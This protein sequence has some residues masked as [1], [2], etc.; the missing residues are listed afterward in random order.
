M[1]VVIKCRGQLGLPMC[2]SVKDQ[3]QRNSA[4]NYTSFLDIWN[5]LSLADTF[6]AY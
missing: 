4:I 2:L 1:T 5:P 6:Y 3:S